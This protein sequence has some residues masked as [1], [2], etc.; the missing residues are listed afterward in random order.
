MSIKKQIIAIGGSG[1]ASSDKYG[2]DKLAM[3][4]YFLA[5]TGKENPRVCFI[6]TA[7][8]DAPVYIVNFYQAF[9]ALDCRP[10]HL[11]LFNLPTADLESFIMHQDAI[12]VGGGNTKSMIALWREWK[13]DRYL[14]QAWEAGVVVG[15]VSAGSICWFEEGVTDSIPGDLTRVAALGFL[16][17][18]NCP[19]YD[20]EKNRRPMYKKL[21]LEGKIGPGLAID[22]YVAVRFVDDKIKEIFSLN[23]D[24]YAYLVS[25]NAGEIVEKKIL[26]DGSLE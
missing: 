7:S 8:G 10:S 22:D 18:S 5:Q 3:E 17:G 24:A 11:S 14:R 6:P 21:L 12:F 26:V 16:K 4:R 2:H 1:F 9:N 13:L 23:P 15:G 20:G 19:H 25:N